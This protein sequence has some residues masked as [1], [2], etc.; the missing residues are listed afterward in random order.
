MQDVGN[1]V[2]VVRKF[3]V[4]DVFSRAIDW[5]GR[6]GVGNEKRSRAWHE[7]FI[8]DRLSLIVIRL[9]T[10]RIPEQRLSM[11][12][13]FVFPP[14]QFDTSAGT[15]NTSRLGIKSYLGPEMSRESNDF[16]VRRQSCK[17]TR[18]AMPF[19][20]RAR[21]RSIDRST[22]SSITEYSSKRK[23]GEKGIVLY[24]SS[25]NHYTFTPHSL[26]YITALLFDPA[27]F[28]LPCGIIFR[29]VCFLIDKRN[30]ICRDG[31]I[32][33]CINANYYTHRLIVSY[34]WIFY[35]LFLEKEKIYAFQFFFFLRLIATNIFLPFL[36]LF[37][38]KSRE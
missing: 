9:W 10:P 2:L 26:R 8:V 23:H 24:L 22:R 34:S 11:T 21:A 35:N 16:R 14:S 31:C 5:R 18:F 36:D 1:D 17:T 15:R 38:E 7:T 37:D 32:S 20:E 30:N 3:I 28:N 25:K 19:Q 27:L 6:K 13:R 33:I 29:R 4:V 12:R